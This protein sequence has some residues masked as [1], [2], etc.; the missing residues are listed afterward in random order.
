M[1]KKSCAIAFLLVFVLMTA[2]SFAQN[3]QSVTT[4]SSSSSATTGTNIVVTSVSTSDTGDVS[5]SQIT[6]SKSSGPGDFSISDPSTGS[7]SGVTVTTSGITKTFTLTAGTAGTY[8][9]KVTDT[10]S[11]GSKA[12]TEATLEF[13]EP[14]ALTV[15]AN[16]SSATKSQGDSFALSISVQNPQAS[17][18]LTSYTLSVPSQFTVSGDPTS[19]SGT[20]I[21]ASATKT[22]SWTLNLATCYTGSKDVTFELGSNS[23]ASTVTVT[24]GNSSCTTSSTNT[25]S[26]SSSSG[27]G[28]GGG[29]TKKS[30]SK[31]EAGNSSTLVF[32][33]SNIESITL[34]V[35][36]TVRNIEVSVSE[37]AKPS[38][39]PEPSLV[40]A[41]VVLYKYLQISHVNISNSDTDSA[42]IRFKVP[43][44]WIKANNIDPAKV[45]L[46]RYT[47]QWDKIP[48]VKTA[49][50]D[51]NVFY[52]ATSPGLSVFVITAKKLTASVSDVANPNDNNQTSGNATSS[53]NQ[54]EITSYTIGIISFVVLIVIIIFGYFYFHKFNTEDRKVRRLKKKFEYK[55]D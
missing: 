38:G 3:V 43:A 54:A 9:Y 11:G 8:K 30:V 47:T 48:T 20:T 25:S 40:D 19:S 45:E 32:S 23:A 5:N 36:N 12:S 4:S 50:T 28:G 41:D 37:G 35:K 24:S 44:D 21:S 17:D 26:S 18:V 42:V 49:E 14:S 22:F 55:R 51:L 13:L 16:P 39:A 29:T 46:W 10:W 34:K 1:S 52:E 53:D 6:L 33:D 2:P 27:G 31:I 15:T 7:Y